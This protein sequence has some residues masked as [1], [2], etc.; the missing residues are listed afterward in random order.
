MMIITCNFVCLF[1]FLSLLSFA[2]GFLLKKKRRITLR[3]L[4]LYV[5]FPQ[6]FERLSVNTVLFFLTLIHFSI[7][8]NLN[9]KYTRWRCR[10]ARMIGS[11]ASVCVC[12]WIPSGI[13]N[14]FVSFHR[15]GAAIDRRENRNRWRV[16][17][18]T[19]RHNTASTSST[20]S[21]RS[22]YI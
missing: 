11:P 15:R 14:S 5:H 13:F 1:F 3:L 16:C 2:F 8:V 12:V 9:R 6:H 20:S 4:F 19:D 18:F 17:R 22:K 21:S 10:I 7:S